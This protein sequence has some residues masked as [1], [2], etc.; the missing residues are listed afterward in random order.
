MKSEDDNE[1]PSSPDSEP[2]VPADEPEDPILDETGHPVLDLGDSSE[3]PEP[4]KKKKFPWGT[5]LFLL[6]LLGGG[7]LGYP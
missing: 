3:E 5:I 4:E 1:K 6:I 2:D 7:F